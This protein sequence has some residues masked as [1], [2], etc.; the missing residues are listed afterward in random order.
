MEYVSG[1]EKGK[2]SNFEQVMIIWGI[3]SEIF[4]YVRIRA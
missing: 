1:K 3:Y 2:K 4:S